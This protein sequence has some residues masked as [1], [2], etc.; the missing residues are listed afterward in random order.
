[1]GT[2][3]RPGAPASEATVCQ[4]QAAIVTRAGG[5]GLTGPA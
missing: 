4:S 3:L 2:A 1:M 5:R